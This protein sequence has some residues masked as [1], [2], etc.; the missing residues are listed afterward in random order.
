MLQSQWTQAQKRQKQEPQAFIDLAKENII[1]LYYTVYTTQQPKIGAFFHFKCW[2]DG[3][4]LLERGP[5]D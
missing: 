4:I 2:S 1:M 5:T 3:Q